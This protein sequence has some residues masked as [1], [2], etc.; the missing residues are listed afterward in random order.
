MLHIAV[1][2]QV[3]KHWLT[4]L[5]LQSEQSSITTSSSS[6]SRSATNTTSATNTAS[7]TMMSVKVTTSTSAEIELAEKSPAA[8]KND[9]CDSLVSSGSEKQVIIFFSDVI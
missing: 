2:E 5:G 9:N 8:V 7:A 1:N 3:K 6:A 4:K